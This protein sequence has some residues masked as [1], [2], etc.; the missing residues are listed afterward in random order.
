MLEC[1]RQFGLNLE[2]SDRVKEECGDEISCI[3]HRSAH[4]SPN[5]QPPRDRKQATRPV[6][7]SLHLAS[8]GLNL[9]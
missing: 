9:T 2:S 7:G 8:A 3:P 1:G 5:H 4:L 6:H